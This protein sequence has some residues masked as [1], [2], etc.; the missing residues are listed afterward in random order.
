MMSRS[1][2][3]LDAFFDGRIT[4][5][6]SRTGYR[7]SLDAL[8]LAHFVTVKTGARIVDLGTGNGVIPLALAALHPSI[9]VTG[10]ELQPRMVERARRNIAQNELQTQIK[11]ARGDVRSP[12]QIGGAGDFDVAV[13]NPPYRKST[14]G[15]LSMNE[16]RQVARHEIAGGL[17]EFV[18]AGT[19]FLRAKGRMA[20]VYP[21]VRSVDL[22]TA[23][24]HG[25]LEPK[26]LRMVHSFRTAKASLILAE[27]IKGGR[28]G[29]AVVAP[30]SVYEG[31]TYSDEVASMIAGT[32]ARL[33]HA[34]SGD[35]LED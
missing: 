2:E 30:L 10:I 5:Y 34:Q 25:G 27:A 1:D 20:M 23:M 22:L 9:E 7:F 14:S 8:L 13:C 3:S 33:R 32:R 17:E 31:A 4:L 24:R 12:K 21:A 29:L 28:S 18:R 11:I 6:Q 19:F 16:E 26:R 15:R 35:A